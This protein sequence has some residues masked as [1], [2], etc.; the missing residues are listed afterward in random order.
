MA[1][2]GADRPMILTLVLDP[3]SSATFDALRRAHFPPARNHLDAHVTM[4]HALSG[5]EQDVRRDVR[6][7][8]STRRAFPVPV[9]GL[10]SLGGGVAFELASP[11]L[12]ELR[13]DLASRWAAGLTRQ[14]RAGFRPHV[15]VQNKVRADEAAALLAEL[16]EGFT[17]WSAQAGGLALW[18]YLGGPW[19]HLETVPFTG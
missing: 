10:R 15:T 6:D 9:T 11:T 5:A 4:F 17:P 1:D 19:E 3:S 2:V 12:L 13:A 8:A 14:D 16:R 7:A 18:R